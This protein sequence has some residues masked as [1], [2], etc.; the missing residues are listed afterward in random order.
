MCTYTYHIHMRIY[1]CYKHPEYMHIYIHNVF[2]L[3]TC[4]CVYIYITTCVHSDLYSYID[5]YVCIYIYIYLY[6]N[7]IYI[8]MCVNVYIYT[9]CNN[10]GSEFRII[11][12]IQWSENLL[13]PSIIDSAQDRMYMYIYLYIYIYIYI[14][15]CINTRI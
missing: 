8:Y 1:A 9:T 12:G 13:S 3:L 2:Y 4:V 15:I 5:I 14:Y 7:F 10:P 6:I 11:E